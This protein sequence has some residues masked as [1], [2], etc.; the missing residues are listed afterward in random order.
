MHQEPGTNI[1]VFSKSCSQC[2][3]Q[4]TYQVKAPDGARVD[5]KSF[6]VR[7]IVCTA[8]QTEEKLEDLGPNPQV[9]GGGGPCVACNE[10]IPLFVELPAGHTATVDFGRQVHTDCAEGRRRAG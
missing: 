7:E 4:V 10:K 3:A 6:G 5:T 8:H 2:A 1:H 9:F